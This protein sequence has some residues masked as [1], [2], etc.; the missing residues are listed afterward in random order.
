[1]VDDNGSDRE[2]VELKPERGND[3]EE[4]YAPAELRYSNG[5]TEMV[6]TYSVGE[7]TIAA[8][9]FGEGN[10]IAVFVGEELSFTIDE[11]VKLLNPL[12]RCFAISSEGYISYISG[13][14]REKVFNV[15]NWDGEP[16]IQRIVEVARSPSFTPDGRYVAYWRLT[17]HTVYCYDMNTES[18]SGQF[19]TEQIRETNIGVEGV[20]YAGQPAFRISDTT[21]GGD[22]VLAHISPEGELID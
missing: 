9:M 15:V 22:E 20:N 4:T 14:Q 19:D 18:D 5:Q 3:I 11:Y 12:S 2:I 21:G 6:N 7:C 10:T 16:I 17:D 13:E 1:M 8:P